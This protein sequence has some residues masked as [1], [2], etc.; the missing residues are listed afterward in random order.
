MPID[1]EKWKQD[2]I[3]QGLM[4][5]DDGYYHWTLRTREP[6]WDLLVERLIDGLIEMGC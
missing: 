5:D 4:K 3:E 2:M 6:D 1:A